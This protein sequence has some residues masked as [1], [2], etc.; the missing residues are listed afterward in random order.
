MVT[1]FKRRSRTH[2]A[3]SADYDWKKL[4]PKV[5]DF[6]KDPATRFRIAKAVS[7]S[8]PI[9][10]V[11]GPPT[12]NNQPHIGHVRGRMMKDLWYRYRT[13]EGE[14]IVFRG[15]W[16]TQGLP[17]ELQAEKEM[18]LSGDKG[19]DL[20]K[21]G[22]EKLVE[23][24]KQLIGKYKK[25]WEEADKLLGVMIDHEKAYMTYRDAYIEREW[26]YLE[27][28]WKKGLLGEGFKVVPFCPKCQ[29]AL[30]AAE[31]SLGGYEQLEDPSLYFKAKLADGSFLILWTTMP[32]TVVTDE[33][34]GVKPDSD[35][36]YFEAGD[37][38]WVV[39]TERVGALAKELGVEFGPTLKTVKG[40]DMEGLSYQHPLLDEIPGLNDARFKGKIHYVVAEEY[41]DVTTGTGLVH[42][43]PANGEEDFAAAQRRGIPVFA[44]FDD[45]V[46]F[47][48]DA[49]KFAGLFARDADEVVV[50]SLREKGA[51]VKA[52]RI[53]HEYPICWRSDD[54]LVWL[55]RR[56][57]FYWVD[58]VRSQLV[59]AA[60]SVDYFFEAPRNRFLASLAESPP[61]CITRERFWGTPLPIWACEK[62]GKKTGAFSRKR[63][64]ELAVETPDG[65]DFELH[66]P[67]IDRVVLKCPSCGGWAVREPFVLDTWHN[68]GASPYASFTDVEFKRL[69]PVG[70]L[71][72]GIDQTR[73]WA[74]TLLLLNVIMKGK[75]QSPYREFL[76]QGHVLDQNGVKMSKSLG[77]VIQGLDLLRNNSVD[78][79]RLYVLSKASPPDSVS[80]DLNEMGG[81]PYQVINTL[82]HLHL[83]LQQNGA[84]DGFDSA[85]NSLGWA[86]KRKL[87]TTVDKWMLSKLTAAED[88][89][90]ESY[91][92][93]AFNDAAKS[94]EELVINHLSQT[95][96]RL[97][98]NE[99]WKDEPKERGRRLA[100]YSV[101][102]EALRTSD[103]LLHP[104]SPFATEFLYQEVFAGKSWKTPLLAVGR[105]RKA[106]GASSVAEGIV[107]LALLAE[108]ACNSARTRAKLKRR[109]PLRTAIL[110]VP[111][112]MAKVASRARGTV[113][114]LCNVK[115]V[116][117]ITSAAKFPARFFL[118]PNSSRVGAL[119]KERTKDVLAAIGPLEGSAAL[120]AYLSTKPLKVTT[121][122][123][124]V[125]LPVST[126]E[127]LTTPRDGYEVAEKGG[128]F[129]SISK[130]RDPRLVAE[131]LV[132]DVARRL[133][134]LRKEKGFV[135]TAMLRSASVAGLEDEDLDLLRPLAK[136]IAFLVRVKR[137]ELAKEKTGG[138]WA[139]SD[140]DGRPIYLKV[141]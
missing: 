140:L 30:S 57:Y 19:E 71:T 67:W 106:K 24:C 80:L 96:I 16:D 138:D 103:V 94:L 84:V 110:L 85:K 123:G 55:A 133:Q 124:I 98:R 130:E 8:R 136:D 62:C 129:V 25:D 41:V 1:K 127:L 82:Y 18:G 91:G 17:V 2:E 107:D 42:M 100:I 88:K 44:P 134:A 35:Y 58:R 89:V 14:N 63:I 135:P 38:T 141:G 119:F 36:E 83:Y 132:R 65:R 72:E 13:L 59:E 78:V 131:G 104:I 97:V 11:D 6:Y 48:V 109:W 116:S 27:I 15:G 122:S 118:R 23:A 139:E 68:S 51:L 120:K 76:F 22:V 70:F 66:R 10:Y 95:Y 33:L 90:V 64:L 121:P 126:F 99:L 46:K 49:G 56:E 101:L 26:K 86:T 117:V 7:K 113:A 5:R 53:T 12:L 34:V 20:R 74:Y 79:L 52:G 114:L 92:T 115:E 87:L 54:R 111:A 37:E 75:P 28:A 45:E 61:W 40:K 73:G 9:G 69:V 93:A 112:R 105:S 50:E 47:T 137:V 60:A 3:L 29:T 39:C 4:E 102:G 21:V 32:F 108:E 128:M 125:E 77:N 31:V 43:S 81:R